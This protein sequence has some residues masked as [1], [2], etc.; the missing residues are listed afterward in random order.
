MLLH[1]IN[2]SIIFFSSCCCYSVYFHVSLSLCSSVNILET[3]HRHVDRHKMMDC[4]LLGAHAKANKL[5][6]V[7]YGGI[8]LFYCCWFCVHCKNLSLNHVTGFFFVWLLFHSMCLLC[9]I[10]SGALVV[11][12]KRISSLRNRHTARLFVCVRVITIQVFVNDCAFVC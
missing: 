9:C 1:L 10:E 5:H 3:H 4:R 11:F 7:E 8:C 6:T 12:N 2:E